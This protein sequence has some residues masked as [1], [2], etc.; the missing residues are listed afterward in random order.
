M[1]VDEFATFAHHLK[2]PLTAL[3][4]RIQLAHREGH[5]PQESA[6]F[7]LAQATRLTNLID[8]ERERLGLVP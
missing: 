4:A 2:T 7:L 5:L 3:R 1:S 8:A 6:D